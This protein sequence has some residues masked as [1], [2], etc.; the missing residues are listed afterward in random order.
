[1]RRRDFVKVV[2]TGSL[3]SLACPR[4]GG[5]APAVRPAGPAVRPAGPAVRPAPDL[6]RETFAA[7]HA[8]RDGTEF[9]IPKPSR[10]LPVVIVGGG[11]A[12]LVAAREL[13]DRDYLVIEKEDWVGGNATGGAWRGVGYSSGTS[14]NNAADVKALAAE[15]GVRLLPIASVDGA[16][17]RDTFV[18]DF[19]TT[20]LDRSPYPPQVRDGFRRFFDTY[21]HYD[22]EREAERL[23]NQPFAE[24]LKAYPP[25]LR[26]FFDSFG[27]N[28]WAARVEDTSAYVGIQA[29]Q[30]A[31]G[32]EPARYTGEQGFGLLT[33]ALGERVKVA[34]PGRLLTGRTV[35]QVR[36][37]GGRVVVAWTAAGNDGQETAATRVECVSA[38]TV[39]VAAPKFI[40]RHLV[41]GLP[42]EQRAAMGHIRY[43]PYM[44]ANLC[45]DG[46]VHESCFDTNVIGPE[47]ISDFVCADW[48]SRR[49]QG[50]A[51]RPTVLTCYMPLVETERY[52]LLDEDEARGMAFAALDRLDRWF[53]GALRKCR[54]IRVRLR[55]HPMHFS[56]QGMITRWGPASRRSLGAIHFAGTDGMGD[57]SE[58]STALQSGRDA[59]RRAIASLDARARRR[60]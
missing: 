40:A 26:T 34:G 8:L 6:S 39:I 53:P 44:V 13:Q 2:I 55:G 16:I 37:D 9:A 38:D 60:G 45:F 24:V 54:E 33:R 50:K 41:A 43:A 51:D 15:L 28:S 1:M 29:A 18:P 46:V 36:Q 57:V 58:L 4:G 20:G 31:G 21:A 14:Y 12:G 25:E 32:L 7:C 49:G 42:E 48:P 52:R 23:D 22:V 5:S 19:L 56:A 59:A 17:I 3:A 35:L 27:P 47:P 11:P 30:W 10:H